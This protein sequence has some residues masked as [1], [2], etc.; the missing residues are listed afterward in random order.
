MNAADFHYSH[1][2]PR[3]PA[4]VVATNEVTKQCRRCSAD[5]VARSPARKRCDA[6]QS[7]VTAQKYVKSL[8]K[9]KAKRLARKLPRI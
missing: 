2:L 3:R 5:F 6:C 4:V 8:A 7:I 1:L 9:L